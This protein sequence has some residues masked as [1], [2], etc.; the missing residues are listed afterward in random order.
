MADIP[1]LGRAA[2]GVRIMKMN[3][4]DT[5]ASIGLVLP[6]EE[7]TENKAEEKQK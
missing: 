6:D 3:D 4:G 1:T 7:E 2:Q 5:V